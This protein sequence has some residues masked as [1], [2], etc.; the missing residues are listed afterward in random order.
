MIGIRRLRVTCLH[1]SFT[2]VSSRGFRK[3]DWPDIFGGK[4]FFFRIGVFIKLIDSLGML[5][6]LKGSSEFAF[7]M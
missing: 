4:M 6:G 3:N 1:F 2:S 7:A 5:I